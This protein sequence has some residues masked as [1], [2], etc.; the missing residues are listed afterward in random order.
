MTLLNNLLHNDY[1]FFPLWI[2]VGASI[3]YAWWSESTR[4][5]TSISKTQLDN[6][7]SVNTT[8]NSNSIIK[9]SPT[10][11]PH[12]FSIDNSDIDAIET[13]EEQIKKSIQRDLERVSQNSDINVIKTFEERIKDSIQRDLER[14][15]QNFNLNTNQT[16]ITEKILNEPDIYNSK[17]L[18]LL[19]DKVWSSSD[20]FNQMESTLHEVERILTSYP[21]IVDLVSN[22]T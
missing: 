19:P 1:V 6:I 4:V 22:T 20:T 16:E 10:V 13:F 8:P 15:N 14:V 9:D 2:G 21:Q 11:V 3:G 18:N 12:N 7:S 17:I 5:F